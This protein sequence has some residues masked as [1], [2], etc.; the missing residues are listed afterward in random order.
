MGRISMP[1]GKG[2]QLHNRREYEKIGKNIPENINRALSGENITLVDLDIREAYQ[3]IFGEALLEYNQS[4][5]RADRKIEDYYDHIAKSKNGEKLFY[6]DVLQW[7]KKDDFE[8]NP[9]IKEKAMECLAEYAGTFEERNPN[10]KLIGAYIHMDEASPHLHIDYVPVAHGYSRGLKTRN[11]LDR[12]M[13]EMGFVPDKESRI[14]NAT[15]LWK[16]N[17]RDYFG[18]LCRSKGLDV[19]VERKAR[20][21]L[22]V[23]EY[24]EARDNMLNSIDRDL[25]TLKQDIET[26]RDHAA[27]WEKKGSLYKDMADNLKHKYRELVDKINELLGRKGRLEYE[28]AQ[29]EASRG[30]L[31]PLR[32]EVEVLTMAK[33]IVSGKL[34]NELQQAKFVPA[35]ELDASIMWKLRDEGKLIAVYEDGSTRPVG[36]NKY[37]VFDDKTIHDQE[38]G[39]CK[40]GCTMDEPYVKIPQSVLK[41]LILARDPHKPLNSNLQK[42]IQQQECLEDYLERKMGR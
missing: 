36:K 3:E 29:M 28:I 27:F 13:K 5:K 31:E 37:G 39:L 22:S 21:S 16:E 4:Q 14:N 12:A 17:E 42:L 2:S 15:K 23:E 25:K 9:Q 19:D 24:K 26:N 20:G 1:Q 18:K 41:E 8:H 6:E 35:E 38:K 11:S 30:Q 32:R 7:G 34:N 40:V 10:L 33:D